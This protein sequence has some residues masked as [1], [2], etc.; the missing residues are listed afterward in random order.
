[1][2]V[3]SK[4]LEMFRSR[5][6]RGA[7]E[8]EESGEEEA[9]FDTGITLYRDAIEHCAR[10]YRVMVCMHNLYTLHLYIYF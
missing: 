5:Q 1:M 8:G 10:L 9:T 2:E 7:E 6:T 3:L 4:H